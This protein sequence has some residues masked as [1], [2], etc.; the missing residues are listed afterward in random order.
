[1]E[2]EK[3]AKEINDAIH[4]LKKHEKKN[5]KNRSLPDDP[6]ITEAYIK[7]ILFNFILIIYSTKLNNEFF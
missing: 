5:D 2:T 4:L 1:M 3:L 6:I 7:K